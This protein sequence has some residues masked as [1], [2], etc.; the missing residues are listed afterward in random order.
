MNNKDIIN[1]DYDYLVIGSGFGGAVSALRL[2]EKGYR[3]LV[4]ESGRRFN[5]GQFPKTNWEINKYIWAPIIKCFGIMRMTLFKHVFI[6]SGAGVGGGSLVYANT[7]LVPKDSVWDKLRPIHSFK[8]TLPP[9]YEIAKK[10]LGV[11][12]NIK[13]G[14]ADLILKKAAEYS[15][16][17]H[18][19]YHTDVGIYFGVPG[20]TVPDPYFNGAGPKRT[21][22]IQCGSC[23]TGCNHG[24][25]N[26]LVKNYL[27][28]AEKK[29]AKIKELKT[30]TIIEPILKDDI[31][32]MHGYRIHI[33][34]SDSLFLYN[35]EYVKAKGVI[36][37]AGVLGTLKLLFNCKEK[38]TLPKISSNLGL[39]VRTNSESII[40]ARVNN[41]KI[42]MSEGIAI[43]SGIHIDEHT[44]IEAVRYGNGSDL[45]S[46]ICTILPRDQFYTKRIIA[47]F[48][49]FLSNPLK[50]L[51][52][53]IPFGWAK[54]TL[55]L[56]VMQTLDGK[57]RIRPKKLKYFPFITY[58]QTEIDGGA[59]ISANIPRA[60][61][62]LHSLVKNVEKGTPLTSITEILF[63][64][65][66]TAH[67]LGGAVMGKNSDDSVVSYKNEV[68]NY[69][70][71]FICD[72]SVVSTNLGVNPSLTI[73]A[74]TEHAMSH[75]EHKR[76]S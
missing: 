28:L 20:N 13:L 41:K 48:F 23:M 4:I 65:P 3:V 16:F 60:N 49:E 33:K 58:L 56:L 73:T 55:I 25:K 11:T 62:F 43:G 30:A 37:S 1:Y 7:L 64:V 68:H 63:N 18:T 70:N 61:D 54:S 10:M 51:K 6:L 24:A 40:G 53:L 8:D 32:G 12:Q 34:N 75:I 57:I 76:N 17:A 44:H 45:L 29:G 38:K 47:A 26:T 39:D 71:L 19:F 59:P 52:A 9:F 15:N 69:K 31:Y 14:N 66:T 50:N 27:Y 2:T 22:C 5:D 46:L 72:G 35:K 21:G 42:D 74:L 67:I 36:I